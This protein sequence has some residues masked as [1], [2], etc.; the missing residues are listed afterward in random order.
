MMCWTWVLSS[1]TFSGSVQIQKP[2]SACLH[3]H[4]I[5]LCICGTDL[6]P[7]IQHIISIFSFSRFLLLHLMQSNGNIK[8]S[9]KSGCSD[10]KDLQ[11]NTGLTERHWFD[12]SKNYSVPTWLL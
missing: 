2:N 9:D 7:R 8:P 5:L 3:E 11:L 4:T 6:F 12:E 1:N 10:V